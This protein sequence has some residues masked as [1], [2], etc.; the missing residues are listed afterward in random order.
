MQMRTFTPVTPRPRGGTNSEQ[1]TQGTPTPPNQNS[2][3]TTGGT[4][5]QNSNSVPETV[6]QHIRNSGKLTTQLQRLADVSFLREME[7]CR[8]QQ[9]AG[10]SSKLGPE[11]TGVWGEILTHLT[12]A[13]ALVLEAADKAKAASAAEAAKLNPTV[14]AVSNAPVK[15]NLTAGEMKRS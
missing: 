5:P 13:R 11:I 3:A 14:E 12:R 6:E 10:V 15:S 2:G 4:A 1:N 7:A 9:E 8:H